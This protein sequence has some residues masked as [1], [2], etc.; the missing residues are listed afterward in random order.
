MNRIKKNQD[1]LQELNAWCLNYTSNDHSLIFGEQR[2]GVNPHDSPEYER[3]KY[4][5]L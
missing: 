5:Y 4:R 3:A 1:T 2:V